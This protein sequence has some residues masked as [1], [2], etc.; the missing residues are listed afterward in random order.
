MT[1]ENTID[2][3]RDIRSI[4]RLQLLSIGDRPFGRH[5]AFILLWLPAFASLWFP[6]VAAVNLAY[7]HSVTLFLALLAALL[8]GAFYFVLKTRRIDW[9][10]FASIEID[11]RALNATLEQLS[12]A[13]RKIWH[14]LR[15]DQL[16]VHPRTCVSDL[17]QFSD[18]LRIGIF[19]ANQPLAKPD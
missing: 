17:L 9:T 10:E 7:P 5:A 15:Q 12:P 16:T 6:P 14:D 8:S 18:L 1:R 2:F 19:A 4:E 11:Q 3:R 13:S